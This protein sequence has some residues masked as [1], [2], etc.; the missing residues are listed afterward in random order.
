MLAGSLAGRC[1]VVIYSAN[2]LENQRDASGLW[3]L[4]GASLAHLALW[5]TSDRA[6]KIRGDRSC[7]GPPASAIYDAEY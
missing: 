6:S 4:A 3:S 1:A 5:E 2:K 7:Q